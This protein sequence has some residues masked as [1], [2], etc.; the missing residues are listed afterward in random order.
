MHDIKGFF[1]L[2]KC[3]FIISVERADAEE[4]AYAVNIHHVQLPLFR[5]QSSSFSS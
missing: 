1:A 3:M 5:N 2:Q 4:G